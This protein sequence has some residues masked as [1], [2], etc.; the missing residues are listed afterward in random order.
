MVNKVVEYL[1]ALEVD[2]T[3]HHDNSSKT[4]TVNV[5][6]IVAYHNS[7]KRDLDISVHFNAASKTDIARGVEVLYYSDFTR[8]LAT[9][10][11]AAISK[12]SGLKDRGPKKRT[13]LGFLKRTAIP[14][15]LIEVCFVDSKADVKAYHDNFDEI[16]K[17]I[18][19]SLTGKKLEVK[20]YHTV[21][22]GDTVSDI[23]RKYQV[24][25]KQI[26]DLNK[27][28]SKYTIELVKSYV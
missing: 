2:V 7:K 21:V 23:S 27:L 8:T 6:G 20:K 24:T 11:S 9:I 14:S 26:K 15:I 3:K 1:G 5:N 22:K 13:D 28:N 19:E 10:V 18:A 12:A 16:C 4:R 17:A 25:I